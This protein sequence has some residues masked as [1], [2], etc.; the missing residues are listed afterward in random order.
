M[1]PAKDKLVVKPITFREANEFVKQFH[2][3]HGGVTGCKFCIALYESNWLVGVAI[4]GRPVSRRLDDGL[5][6]EINRCC[7]LDG[8]KNACSMLYGRCCKI[9][10]A[11]GYTKAITYTLVS[12]NGASCKASNFENK[13]VA[14]GL[15]WSG[16]RNRKIKSPEEMKIRWE[17]ML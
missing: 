13:G 8:Y 7:V 16:C 12:E 17:K 11:M 5:T 15:H 10:K 1:I 2:R 14:G 6:L 3:H 9:A 4:C